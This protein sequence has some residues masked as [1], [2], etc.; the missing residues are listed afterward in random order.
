MRF[1]LRMEEIIYMRNQK[2]FPAF[3]RLLDPCS[4]QLHTNSS[5]ESG[6]TKEVFIA[7]YNEFMFGDWFHTLGGT[8]SPAHRIVPD[9]RLD[10]PNPGSVMP[11]SSLLSQLL[12]AEILST[13]C[14]APPQFHHY[15]PQ[16][17]RYHSLPAEQRTLCQ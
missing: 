11:I 16:R 8:S 12:L 4:G 17:M 1:C 14:D 3:L 9:S 7:G 13:V 2:T 5:A 10:P 15:L 6:C